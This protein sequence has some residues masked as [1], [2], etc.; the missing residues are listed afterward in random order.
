MRCW[1]LQVRT[2]GVIHLMCGE[3][4]R[5]GWAQLEQLAAALPRLEEAA[6]DDPLWGASPLARLA[7][8]RAAAVIAL[9]YLARLDLRP[10]LPVLRSASS[11]PS[12]STPGYPCDTLHAPVRCL[13][14]ACAAGAPFL[15]GT[16]SAQPLCFT[17]LRPAPLCLH[18]QLCMGHFLVL[19]L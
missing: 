5:G 6:L 1:I 17:H 11:S 15:F 4:G 18:S 3:A 10:V 13:T 9:P 7:P 8:Y 12:V 16:V 19:G 2:G 14:A